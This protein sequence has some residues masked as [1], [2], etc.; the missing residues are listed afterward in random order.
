MASSNAFPPRMKSTFLDTGDQITSLICVLSTKNTIKRIA[1]AIYH[2]TVVA[3][4]LNMSTT[5]EKY[6]TRVKSSPS[7]IPISSF[8]FGFWMPVPMYFACNQPN[9]AS[10]YQIA[11]R[12][13]DT[14]DIVNTNGQWIFA[15]SSVKVF[16]QRKDK[17]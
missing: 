8:G 17:K 7:I 4:Q 5:P 14:R 16:I 2:Q 15:H 3:S 9:N 13:S 6:T 1:S 11:P 10:P 12:K